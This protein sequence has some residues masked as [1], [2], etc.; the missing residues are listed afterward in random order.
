[1]SLGVHCVIKQLS[2]GH[3]SV[4]INVDACHL[5]FVECA[6]KLPF[7]F[8]HTFTFYKHEMHMRK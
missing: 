5:S 7:L 2:V 6:C 8:V 1:M 3:V 4:L